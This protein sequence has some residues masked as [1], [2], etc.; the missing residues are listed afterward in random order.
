MPI[1]RREFLSGSIGSGIALAAG[2]SRPDTAVNTT[3]DPVVWSDEFQVNPAIS[4][5]KVV[6]CHDDRMINGDSYA[7]TF[8]KQNQ[9]IDT[10]RVE[11]NM[12]L[13]AK[14]LTGKTNPAQAWATIF[15]KPD[16]KSW[17][18][19]KA[20]VKINGINPAIMHHIALVGKV[21]KELVNL[22]IEAGN[23]IVYDA[24]HGA[25]GDDKYTPYIDNGLPQG[26]VVSD[27]DRN[28]SVI[29][30]GNQQPCTTIVT[31]CD[32]LVN[33]AVNKGHGQYDKGG[34]TLT[35][36]NHTGTM[37]FSCPGITEMIEMN[38][39]ELILGGNPVRQQLCI[40]DSLWASDSGPVDPPTH[41]PCRIVMGTFGPLVDV[42]VT[43]NIREQVMKA[44]HNDESID[45]IC[46]S[47]GY[48]ESD[49]EWEEF[50]P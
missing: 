28:G 40:V 25:R 10:S 18:S 46:S 17:E 11:A 23:I 37:L 30:W 47:F 20:A 36:K 39:S 1:S 45:F 8:L 19:V 21:C 49:I 5:R 7:A 22:G 31:G 41:V 48:S 6:C 13:L 16:E 29:V 42:A 9:A 15:R 24:G 38:K 2:C 26:T 50:S 34:F 35:M 3:P 14:H 12:D 32:I 43:R 44:S 33:C 4:N 27:G